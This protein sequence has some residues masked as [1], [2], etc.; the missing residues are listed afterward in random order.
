[1]LGFT[2]WITLVFIAAAIGAFASA[3]AGVF[4]GQLN[5]PSWA[6]PAWLFG[7]VWSALYLL[8]GIAA[9]LVWR[10]AGFAQAKTALSLF[11]IQL[12]LNALWS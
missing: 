8:M 11:F 12:A 5:Q 6:P 3:Q 9:F 7:P 1:M 4:Y 2:F 10:T